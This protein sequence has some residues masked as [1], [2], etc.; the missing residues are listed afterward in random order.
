MN[1]LKSSKKRIVGFKQTLKAINNKNAR[2]VYL[3][4]D[5]DEN[6]ISSIIQACSQSSIEV[7]NIYS[8]KELGDAC[9]IEVGA[10]TVALLAD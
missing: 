1:E 7:I 4:K 2:K 6:L 3:A 8:M 10:S 9:G 5:A